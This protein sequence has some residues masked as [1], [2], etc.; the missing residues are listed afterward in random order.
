MNVSEGASRTTAAVQRQ[1]AATE[2]K[3]ETE[4]DRKRKHLRQELEDL[5]TSHFF[6][7]VLRV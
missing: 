5:G 2:P 3:L 4:E 1:K 7:E 6:A